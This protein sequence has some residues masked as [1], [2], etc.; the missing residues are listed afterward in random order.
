ML[1][2]AVPAAQRL[3]GQ[4]FVLEPALLDSADKD[5]VQEVASTVLRSLPVS[6]AHMLIYEGAAMQGCIPDGD[7]GR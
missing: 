5:A 4:G 3:H 2:D 7:K 1:S 6:L